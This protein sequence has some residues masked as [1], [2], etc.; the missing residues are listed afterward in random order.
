MEASMHIQLQP[1]ATCAQGQHRLSRGRLYG[2]SGAQ[3]SVCRDCGCTLVRNT[4]TRRWVF[5]GQLG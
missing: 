2:L 1:Q 5:S 3:R 4:V